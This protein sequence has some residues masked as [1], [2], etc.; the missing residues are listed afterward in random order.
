MKIHDQLPLSFCH[1]D[2]HPLNVIWYQD[3]IK[4][5]IDW[6]FTGMNPDIYDAANLVGCAGIE[7]PNGLGM[8]MVKTFLVALG[9][10]GTQLSCFFNVADTIY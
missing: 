10:N 3:R 7:N 1:G 8:S 9:L 2:L 5:V 4:A 6:E